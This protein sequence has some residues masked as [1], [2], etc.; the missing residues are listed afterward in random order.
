M[1]TCAVLVGGFEGLWL[2]AKPDHLAHNIPTVCYGETEGVKLGDTYTKQ[3]CLDMLSGKLPRY[4]KEIARCI[5]VPI[6]DNE[7]IAYTS[8]AYN[9]GSAGFCRSN[10]AHH[11]NSGD[12][13]G[14]CNAL[15]AWDHA[16]GRRVQGL[17][18]RRAKER[19]LCLKPSPMDQALDDFVADKP[20]SII[21]DDGSF[22]SGSGQGADCPRDPIKP[23][24]PQEPKALVCHRWWLFWKVCS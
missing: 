24:L 15:M 3:E 22:C 11:L 7:K 8:F 21:T 2:T 10:V 17:T 23:K 20:K 12:H 13:R 14:A 1:A 19:V 9:V 16:G 6:S 5:H 4:W 18:N